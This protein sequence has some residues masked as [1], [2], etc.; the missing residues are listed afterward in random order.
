M[1]L[2][3][4]HRFPNG[5][6]VTGVEAGAAAEAGKIGP[7]DYITEIEGS[8]A[9]VWKTCVTR[10]GQRRAL[11]CAATGCIELTPEALGK[12]IGEE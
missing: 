12:K 3:E 11:I 4:E 10:S 6:L 2:A 9:Q 1:K 7:G 5:L 8:R